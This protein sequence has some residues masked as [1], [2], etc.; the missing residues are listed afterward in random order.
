MGTPLRGK[1][2]SSWRRLISSSQAEEGTLPVQPPFVLNSAHLDSAHLS[3]ASN[4]IS[5]SQLPRIALPLGFCS[6][7]FYNFGYSQLPVAHPN[8]WFAPLPVLLSEQSS[9]LRPET[10]LPVGSYDKLPVTYPTEWTATSLPILRTQRLVPSVET[11][12]QGGSV[13][14]LHASVPSGEVQPDARLILLSIYH[15]SHFWP[16][17]RIW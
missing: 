11:P 16:P 17:N 4:D 6:L 13:D 9:S 15:L 14:P 12:L 7:P 2:D 10:S 3:S 8:E 5:L 1:T